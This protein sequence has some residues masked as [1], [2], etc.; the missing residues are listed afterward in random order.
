M[1]IYLGFGGEQARDALIHAGVKHSLV[2]YF[3]M[4]EHKLTT[5]FLDAF[6]GVMLDSGAFSADSLNKP[7]KIDD[8]IQFAKDNAKYFCT[9]V[10]LDVIGDVRSNVKS[11]EMSKANLRYMEKC[12]VKAIPVFHQTE[13]FKYLDYYCENY[14]YVGLGGVGNL[15]SSKWIGTWLTRVF[16]RH[17][18]HKFHGFAI[19]AP[20][21]MLKFPFYSVDSTSWAI[22][23]RYGQVLKLKDFGLKLTYIRVRE[24]KDRFIKSF[25]N[26]GELLDTPQKK[27]ALSRDLHNARIFAQLEENITNVWARRGVIWKD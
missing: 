17:P 2:S 6:K 27:L 18:K 16:A 23:S 21:L 8:Y 5:D 9:V 12:G 20:V 15:G 1:R 24:G 10:N 22:G 14:E 3:Y 4:K 26:A 19:T 11:A 25:L 7:I 13:D